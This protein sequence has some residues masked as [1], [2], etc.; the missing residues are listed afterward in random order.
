MRAELNSYPRSALSLYIINAE[1]L[2]KNVNVNIIFHVSILQ[3]SLIG[4]AH[5]GL[6]AG[7]RLEGLNG[8]CL[9]CI[10]CRITNF[11]SLPEE[12]QNY[13]SCCKRHQRDTVAQGVN[14]LHQNIKRDLQR[15]KMDL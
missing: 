12:A 14:G 2:N 1:Y 13:A 8:N 3:G 9:S 5:R 10:L 6:Q 4:L 7:W 15:K 11:C